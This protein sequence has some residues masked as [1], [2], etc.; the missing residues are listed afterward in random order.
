MGRS[1]G[2]ICQVLHS[3]FCTETNLAIEK[4]LQA[5]AAVVSLLLVSDCI[6]ELDGMVGFSISPNVSGRLLQEH[7][8]RTIPPLT[9]SLPLALSR[10]TKNEVAWPN[11]FCIDLCNNSVEQGEEVTLGT[12]IRRLLAFYRAE[13]GSYMSVGEQR[14]SDFG[15]WLTKGD[16]TITADIYFSGYMGDFKVSA[17][18]FRN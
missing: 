10:L 7:E 2:N 16:G 4:S 13:G 5:K 1:D 14:Q 9:A 12:R 15:N 18:L 3:I 11:H 17:I 8:T 6:Y